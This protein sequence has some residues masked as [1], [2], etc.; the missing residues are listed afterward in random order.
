MHCN[1]IQYQQNLNSINFLQSNLTDKKQLT[2][3]NDYTQNYFKRHLAIEQKRNDMINRAGFGFGILLT[4]IAMSSGLRFVDEQLRFFAEKNAKKNKKKVEQTIGKE[5]QSLVN[6]SKIPVLDKCK[7]LNKNLKEFLQN[8]IDILS[9][10]K[11]IIQEVGAKAPNRLIISGPPGSGKS[12]F[13]KVFAKTLNA[14]YMEIIISDT[15]AVHAGEGVQ[16]I[17]NAF[18]NVITQAKKTPDKKFVLTL[19]EVDAY[20]QPVNRYANPAFN[21]GTHWISKMEERDTFLSCIE[22]LQ[23]EAPNVTIIGTTNIS[24]KCNGLDG[25]AVSRFQNIIEISMPDKNMLYEG[26]KMNLGKIK[27]GENFIKANKNKLK[28][29]ASKMEKDKYSFRDLDNLIETSNNY[30]LKEKLKNKNS[31]FRFEFLERARENHGLTDG[32][33]L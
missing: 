22:K 5:F 27:D 26:L 12:F 14:D 17:K 7:S 24:P 1:S 23:E 21:T 16:N 13:A 3:K 2:D 30:Y 10:D 32:N 29:I 31:E 11:E 9:A 28:D 18:E 8:Q 33:L 19:N 15:K 4:I 20:I 25:A 6:N